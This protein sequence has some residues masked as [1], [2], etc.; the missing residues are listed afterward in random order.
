MWN[1][2]KHGLVRICENLDLESTEDQII[3]EIY[4]TTSWGWNLQVTLGECWWLCYIVFF[5][6]GRS[7]LISTT[8]PYNEVPACFS[9][10]TRR[11][12][13]LP[14]QQARLQG[15][16]AENS[17]R[18]TSLEGWKL[19]SSLCEFDLSHGHPFFII[20]TRVG[21]LFR[22]NSK[23]DLQSWPTNNWEGTERKLLLRSVDVI[24]KHTED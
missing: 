18:Q 20:T 9:R 22:L 11:T 12:P 7:W 24:D 2:W 10:T 17:L 14:T 16:Q 23:E 1:I 5:F 21:R 8:Q 13:L 6:N 4:R 15:I 19:Q 3:K